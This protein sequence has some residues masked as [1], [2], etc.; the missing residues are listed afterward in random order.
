MRLLPNEIRFRAVSA[1][2]RIDM[3]RTFAGGSEWIRHSGAFH[4]LVY[5]LVIQCNVG[6]VRGGAPSRPQSGD[7]FAGDFAGLST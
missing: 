5:D 3:R 7:H 1:I 4:A 2:Q 6:H